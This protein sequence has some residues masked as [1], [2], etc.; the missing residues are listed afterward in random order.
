MFNED[1]NEGGF[2]RREIFPLT[3]GIAAGYC[4]V[5]GLSYLNQHYLWILFYH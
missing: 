5:Q 2:I 1:D 3:I 4:L